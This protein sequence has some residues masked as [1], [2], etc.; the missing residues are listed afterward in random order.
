MTNTIGSPMWEYNKTMQSELGW[1][2]FAVT[3]FDRHKNYSTTILTSKSADDA[4]VE[5]TERYP[6]F[7]ILSVRSTD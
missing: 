1:E 6:Q 7:E 4:L 3:Y 2:F 5:F